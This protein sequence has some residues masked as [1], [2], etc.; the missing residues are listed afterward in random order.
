MPIQRLSE[1]RISESNPIQRGIN[2]CGFRFRTFHLQRSSKY[3]KPV[4]GLDLSQ[5]RAGR[6]MAEVHLDRRRLEAV[7]LK[8]RAMLRRCAEPPVC[9]FEVGAPARHHDV[10]RR[11]SQP[12]G[13]LQLLAGGPHG[14]RFKPA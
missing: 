7:R 14:D 8:R 12:F 13:V 9:I 4:V 5:M 1:T 2:E 10:P 11:F 3:H 6:A